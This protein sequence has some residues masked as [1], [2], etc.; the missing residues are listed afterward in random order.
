MRREPA[1]EIVLGSIKA[2]MRKH[3]GFVF[4]VLALECEP[5]DPRL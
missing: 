2:R 5:L 4:G 3:A 1:P